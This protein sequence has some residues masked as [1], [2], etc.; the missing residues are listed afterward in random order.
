MIHMESLAFRE[1][2]RQLDPRSS[3]CSWSAHTVTAVLF[4]SSSWVSNLSLLSW[5]KY[6][7]SVSA[8]ANRNALH[9]AGSGAAVC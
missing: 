2:L 9:C 1:S 8:F 6:S 4:H 7:T 5:G 3:T